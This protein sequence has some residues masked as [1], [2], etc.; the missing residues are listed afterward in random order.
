MKLSKK[1]FL[2]IIG[3]RFRSD[4]VKDNPF[5]DL[6]DED[7]V[8]TIVKTKNSLHFG[9]LYDRYAD[10]IY[11]KCYGFAKSVDE[12]KDLTQDVFLMV[13]V[14]LPSFKGRSKFSSWMYS[15]TY[16][17]CVNYVKRNKERKIS[18]KSDQLDPN[19]YRIPVEVEDRSILNLRSDKLKLAL[20]EID[21]ED[22]SLLLLKYQ[23]D[24]SIKELCHLLEISESAVKMRLKRAKAKMV[25][26]YNLLP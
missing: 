14:K 25:D 5:E 7:L 9:I 1:L 3:K 4:R 16:N 6:S 12:A 11:N 13:Y 2:V 18:D 21:P 8:K 17:F 15:V 22:R 26:I 19:N 20:E 10:R 23:D 24:V